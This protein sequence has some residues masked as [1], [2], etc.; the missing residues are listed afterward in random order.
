MQTDKVAR[1]T[2]MSPTLKVFI[3]EYYHGKLC[4]CVQVGH[5]KD[6]S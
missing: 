2:P 6:M 1:T 3:S 4:T 5:V